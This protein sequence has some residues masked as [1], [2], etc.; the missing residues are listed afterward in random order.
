LFESLSYILD[1]AGDTFS[2]IATSPL[3]NLISK[4][5][6]AKLYVSHVSNFTTGTV[7]TKSPV[8]QYSVKGNY[9]A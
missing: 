5:E 3:P 4:T 8:L 2:G 7:G 1:D 6:F 9:Y